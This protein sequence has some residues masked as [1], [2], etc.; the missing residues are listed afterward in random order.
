MIT[1][2][3]IIT[4]H[5]DGSVVCN[6][7]TYDEKG[8]N[9]GTEAV[10][11]TELPSRLLTEFF[12]PKGEAV[13]PEIK[14]DPDTARMIDETLDADPENPVAESSADYVEK[15]VKKYRASK[16]KPKATSKPKAK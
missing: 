4:Q 16:A 8:N 11:T 2:A 15:E 9:T 14:S 13:E 5:D 6:L 3:M 1:K 12:E 7:T 10:P